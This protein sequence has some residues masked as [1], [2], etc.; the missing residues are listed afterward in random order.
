M[1]KKTKNKHSIKFKYKN[2]KKSK[3]KYTKNKKKKRVRSKNK[4]KNNTK[5][6]SGGAIHSGQPPRPGS[7]PADDAP[8]NPGDGYGPEVA[9]AMAAAMAA[10]GGRRR[11]SAMQ[12]QKQQQAEQERLAAELVEQERLA[13]EQAEQERL[14]AEQAE[15]ERLAAEQAEQERLAA[16][17]AEQD[18][19]AAEEAAGKAKAEE[20]AEA[21]RIIAELA[22]ETREQYS[23][24][25]QMTLDII[26][27]LI[28][29]F[30]QVSENLEKLMNPKTLHGILKAVE[31]SVTYPDTPLG[32]LIQLLEKIQSIT[33][34]DFRGGG[35]CG[36]SFV[37][38]GGDGSQGVAGA[39]PNM[40]EMLWEIHQHLTGEGGE[41]VPK[42]EPDPEPGQFGIEQLIFIAVFLGVIACGLYLRKSWYKSRRDHRVTGQ[43]RDAVDSHVAEINARINL[44]SNPAIADILKNQLTEMERQQRIAK[45]LEAVC[46]KMGIEVPGKGKREIEGDARLES[47]V[48]DANLEEFQRKS[49]ILTLKGDLILSKYYAKKMSK[50]ELFTE[51]FKE[52]ILT[53]SSALLPVIALLCSDEIHEMKEFATEFQDSHTELMHIWNVS[54]ESYDANAG[55]DE[56]DAE[57]KEIEDELD[58]ET[59][60]G[61]TGPDAGDELVIEDLEGDLE[62]KSGV[63]TGLNEVV[64]E[65]E[66]P[67]S[68]KLPPFMLALYK[69]TTGLESEVEI[70]RTLKRE[71]EVIQ[72]LSQE[73]M[74]KLEEMIIMASEIMMEQNR[75]FPH[76]YC[77]RNNNEIKGILDETLKILKKVK[78]SDTPEPEPAPIR[79]RRGRVQSSSTPS[80]QLRLSPKSASSLPTDSPEF[81]PAFSPP[82]V[83][84]EPEPEPDVPPKPT[85][86][87]SKKKKKPEPNKYRRGSS[88]KRSPQDSPRPTMC[89][90]LKIQQS[91]EGE[92]Q[93]LEEK[94]RRTVLTPNEKVKLA[95]IYEE[96]A[97]N[98]HNLD[99]YIKLSKFVTYQ[100]AWTE[101]EKSDKKSRRNKSKRGAT[102]VP[103][104]N[105]P[106]ESSKRSSRKSSGKKLPV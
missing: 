102:V 78:L 64:L 65:E 32:I 90:L 63:A 34:I 7:P 22:K 26:L 86:R 84:P 2:R 33:S 55:E 43:M 96:I 27:L 35:Q 13:A 30:A 49:K 18:R 46:N 29:K 51:A 74:D 17:E 21:A 58:I 47:M 23:R 99:D 57:D 5:H 91:L 8:N 37:R 14:A 10:R 61:E 59:G 72:K 12:F 87:K 56:V 24:N 11:H 31:L 81:S 93:K 92:K 44:L 15:Q 16:E 89:A 4:N 62:G 94:S 100:E 75:C 28:G 79:V 53:T 83:P 60:P 77:R 67:Q 45:V 82:D 88:S 73:D 70:N 38:G 68:R 76:K 80:H 3:C 41:E 20:E 1:N 36:G 97:Q 48:M 25:S 66:T 69:D 85:R 103:A 9:A 39:Q 19:V 101:A 95:D 52:S 6:F 50:G 105:P 104:G 71:M 98:D 106:K 42:P 40:E 54:K